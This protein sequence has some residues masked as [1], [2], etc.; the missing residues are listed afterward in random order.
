MVVSTSQ[1]A[2]LAV[3][4]HRFSI[5]LN[6]R[7]RHVFPTVDVYLYRKRES[8]VC[9][10]LKNVKK[11]QNIRRKFIDQFVILSFWGEKMKDA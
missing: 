2:S 5:D 3:L 8:E 9:E 11:D 6:Q 7:Y 10:L 1:V 4:T